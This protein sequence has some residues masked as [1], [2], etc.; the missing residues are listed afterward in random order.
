V[1]PN[2][3][4]EAKQK[5]IEGI[6]KARV[7][8]AKDGSVKDVEIIEGDP[9]LVDAAKQAIMRWHYTPFMNCGQA[10]EMRSMEHVK[11]ALP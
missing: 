4:E 6:V 1:A 11:F 7:T 10:V 9:L 2:Y 8:V 5:H 3:P